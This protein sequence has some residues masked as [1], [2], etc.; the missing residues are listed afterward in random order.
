LLAV[1]IASLAAPAQAQAALPTGSVT[2][3]CQ[4]CADVVQGE[5]LR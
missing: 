2:L 1:I 4:A 5:R 3:T